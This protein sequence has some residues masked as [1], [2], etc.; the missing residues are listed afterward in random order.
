[1][2]N[3]DAELIRLTLEGDETAFAELV[4]K[5]EKAVRALVWRKIE[6]YHTAEE[7][8]QDIFLKAY[9]ELGTLKRPQS[10]LSW[11]Y[12]SASRR[13]LAWQRKKRLPMVPYDETKSTGDKEA[14]YSQFVVEE[15]QRISEETQREV[16]K[17][18]LAK[19]PESERTVITLHY[20]SDMSSAEIGAFLGVSANTIRS[21]LHRAKQRLQK[22][23]NII[24]EALEHFQ[25]TPNLTEN[26]MQQISQLKPVPPSSKPIIP[27]LVAATSAVFIVLMLGIGSQ[28]LAHFQKPYSLDSQSEM[29]VELLDTPIVSNIDVKPDDRNQVGSESVFANNDTNTLRSDAESSAPTQDEAVDIS[30]NKEQW[31]PVTLEGHRDFIYSITFSPDGDLL[32]SKS[33]DGSLK[34]WDVNTKQ[35]M[36]TINT[37]Q[38]GEIAFSPDGNL[39]ATGGGTDKVVNLWDPDTGELLRTLEEPLDKVSSVAFSPSGDILASASADGWVHLWNPHTGQLLNTLQSIEEVSI[40]FRDDGSIISYAI[41]NHDFPKTPEVKVWELETGQLLYTLEPEVSEV[42]GVA[43]SLDREVLAS[44]G[45]GGVHLWNARTGE[46][47]RSFPSVSTVFLRAA[48]SPDRRILASSKDFGDI[49]LW[50]SETGLL[51]KSFKAHNGEAASL[52]FS[53]D[54]RTLATTGTDNL[55]QLWNITLPD[56]V[57]TPDPPEFL[58]NKD[59][60]TWGEDFDEGHLKAWTKRKL[61]RERVTWEVKNERLHAR[62]VAWCNQRLNVNNQLAE[63]TNYTLRFTA[64][65]L[66]VEQ[67]SVRLNIH[68]TDNANV[69]IFIGKDPADDLTHPLEYAYQFAD[70]RLGSP[71]VLRGTASPDIGYNLDQIDVVFDRGHFYLYSH[72]E[73][74]TDFDTKTLKTVDF[75]GIVVFP[76]RCYEVAEVIVDDFVVSG[77][78]ILDGS[79]NVHP[80][81]RVPVLRDK[82]KQ[83]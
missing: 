36:R 76:K 32:A 79:L 16:V 11:L 75:L 19:L 42:F 73:Y 74:I 44:A 68:S 51:L 27:W 15:N 33:R 70:H 18:L 48:Y 26:I 25:F 28:F 24:R 61:Q 31:V 45:W 52:V 6:D 14:T 7:I 20:F 46:L 29:T 50:D 8:T 17:Q 3:N 77:P 5:Y 41:K 56:D 60:Q 2:E 54:G 62:T 71:E 47:L 4:K 80:K 30:S 65:P 22:D 21:R 78:S 82:L 34:I 57:E 35:L 58:A 72:G 13:C 66:D 12:V 81:N 67:L 83:Q 40:A 55:I 43:F 1:M 63:Q 53:P 49:K 69:G 64:L 9:Q 38:R 39:L 59:L 10:F 37:S 23:E